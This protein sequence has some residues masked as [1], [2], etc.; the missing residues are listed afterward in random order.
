[1]RFG[2]GTKGFILTLLAALIV[3]GVYFG[4]DYALEENDYYFRVTNLLNEADSYVRN[5]VIEDAIPIYNEL[6]REVKEQ[7]L[8]AY[9]KRNLGICY[10]ELS[11]KENK[12]E[13]LTKAILSY[14]EAIKIWEQSTV[15]D[16][17]AE[18][19]SYLGNAYWALSELENKESNLNESLKAYDE[20]IQMYSAN[21][22]DYW[23]VEW[24]RQ[25]VSER[26]EKINR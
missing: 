6:L 24:K 5:G 10:H 1:M 26:L 8:Y 20:A 4:I 18:C 2:K 25:Q 17:C 9:I 7:E 12:T 21:N 16:A 22:Y 3:G 13:N 23:R 19:Y 11:G 15:N 14:K